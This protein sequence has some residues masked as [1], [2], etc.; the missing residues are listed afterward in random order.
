MRGWTVVHDDQFCTGDCSLAQKSAGD[1]RVARPVPCCLLGF[2][3][4][5]FKA[6]QVSL[7]V[8]LWEISAA[9]LIAA[10]P[11]ICLLAR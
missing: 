7:T 3:G 11:T 2:E 4:P 8:T 5:K 1:Q 6:C 9:V 10:A